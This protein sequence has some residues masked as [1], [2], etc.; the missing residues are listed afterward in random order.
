MAA[1]ENPL[2]S[3]VRKIIHEELD[4]KKEP[5]TATIINYDP[6]TNTARVGIDDTKAGGIYPKDDI[7]VKLEKGMAGYEPIK[8]DRVLISYHNGDPDDPYIS[9]IFDDDYKNNSREKRKA[10]EDG[11]KS[12]GSLPYGRDYEDIESKRYMEKGRIGMIHP[13]HKSTYRIDNATGDAD[14]IAS[15]GLDSG[16]DPVARS[17]FRVRS[18]GTI[19]NI[20]G[21]IDNYAEQMNINVKRNELYYNDYPLNQRMAERSQP[22]GGN[23]RCIMARP[24][25]I[26]QLMGAINSMLPGGQGIV[27]HGVSPYGL[28]RMGPLKEFT[29]RAEQIVEKY[30]PN[31]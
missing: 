17:A 18:N 1:N 3:A 9:M 28:K 25:Q 27:L 2:R 14:I 19:Q 29:N 30:F 4:I 10:P 11:P 31:K 23:L 24:E 8:G 12:D 5:Q 26:V 22:L 20:T 21:R 7:P 6:E 15:N 16:E 13:F